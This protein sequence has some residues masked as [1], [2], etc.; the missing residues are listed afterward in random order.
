[1]DHYQTLG[2]GKDA[3]QQDI[4]KAYR[5]LASKHHPDK[6]GD[7]EEFKRVQAA[8]DT[9]S[10]P[11]KRAQY[12]NPNPFG[13]FGEGFREGFGDGSP[14]AD[15]FGDIFGQQRRRPPAR[16]PDGI[17]DVGVSLLQVYQGSTI[18][19]NTG[20]GTFEVAIPQG[21]PDGTRL[22]LQGKGPSRNTEIP[23]GDLIVRIHTEYPVDWGRDREHLFFRLNINAIDAMTGCRIKIVHV[24][25]KKYELN[26]PA[27]TS[28]G[29]K[30][31]MN[32]LG[33]K[34]PQY[35]VLGNL[36][37][38]IELDVPTITNP[39]DKET[40]NSIKERNI[41]GKQVYR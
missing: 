38:I 6:G 32:G 29:T 20:Y 8:Y 24:D 21:V 35:G 9:L 28:H 23:P 15:I 22:R 2:V 26:V 19:V 13:A 40:L 11:N 25:G 17:V 33:I 7:Q 4:K 39:Q 18:V 14:F 5:K 12:D 41:Y 31:K 27:G 34:D 30:L 10:D 3:S 1:M 36:F 16:N 37:V